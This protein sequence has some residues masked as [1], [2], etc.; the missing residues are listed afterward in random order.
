MELLADHRARAAAARGRLT[1]RGWV[2][3]W[4]LAREPIVEAID[5]LGP[6][7]RIDARADQAIGVHARQD[8]AKVV[9]ATRVRV[10]RARKAKGRE[11]RA[12][13]NK[14]R[15]TRASRARGG[16]MPG[17]ARVRIDHERTGR[18][19]G[20]AIAVRATAAIS[21]KG[22]AA[23]ALLRR[24]PLHSAHPPVRHPDPVGP[25]R[26]RVTRRRCSMPR[27]ALAIATSSVRRAM[28]STSAMAMATSTTAR[29]SPDL[30][31]RTRAMRRSLA[32]AERPE[33]AG[34]AR[35]QALALAR[36]AA[37]DVGA[38]DDVGAAAAARVAVAVRAAQE[39]EA[40]AAAA[41]RSRR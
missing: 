19:I 4:A 31:V 2:T 41:R 7:R 18:A 37:V 26:V 3:V 34:L 27:R 36:V 25:R 17:R 12:S 35:A 13:E 28:D 15:E 8:R 6:T 9:L 38:D 10:D 23:T 16:G 11:N 22:V 14:A 20:A 32:A 5:R 30:K 29:T 21:V 39:A 33:F 40:K 1:D 24:P